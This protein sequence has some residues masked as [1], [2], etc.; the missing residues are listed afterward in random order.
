M[1]PCQNKRVLNTTLQD[2]LIEHTVVSK[3]ESTKEDNINLHLT[4]NESSKHLDL[5]I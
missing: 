3:E 4:E 1:K 2:T 5:K